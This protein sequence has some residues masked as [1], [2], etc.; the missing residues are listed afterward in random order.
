MR[1]MMKAGRGRIVNIASVIG[2]MGNAGQTNYA[3][4]KAG[5]IG[6][7]KALARRGR[8][9]QHHGQRRRARLH[10][11]GHDARAQREAV[12]ALREQVPL[13][14]LGSPEDIAMP[15]VFLVSRRRLHHRRDA[16]RE[17]RYVH[18]LI[19]YPWNAVHCAAIG[20]HSTVSAYHRPPGSGP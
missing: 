4:A 9:P 1:G 6:F 11:D 8:I 17:R 13:A 5:M 20:R 3:A 7:T 10:R 15:G 18:D 12:Q 16:A 19:G 14:R 2:V